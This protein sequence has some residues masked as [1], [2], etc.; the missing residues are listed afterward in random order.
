MLTGIFPFSTLP[1]SVLRVLISPSGHPVIRSTGESWATSDALL[2]PLVAFIAAFI[3]R[4]LIGRVLCSMVDVV[5]IYTEFNSVH[6]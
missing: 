5:S 4:G 2:L 1:F 3:W 6:L